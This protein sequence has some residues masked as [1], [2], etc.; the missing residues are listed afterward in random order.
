MSNRKV[1]KTYL[2]VIYITSCKILSFSNLDALS[3]K[4]NYLKTISKALS[5][6]INGT[7]KKAIK[8][9]NL[10]FVIKYNSIIFI[11]SLECRNAFKKA[12]ETKMFS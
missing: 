10:S 12:L 1:A 7:D 6:K 11:S 2:K 3:P 9:K 8:V 5:S 4:D